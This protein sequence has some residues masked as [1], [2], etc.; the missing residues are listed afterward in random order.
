MSDGWIPIPGSEN[1][2]ADDK[3]EVLYE[4]R[5]PHCRRI[6]HWGEDDMIFN[7]PKCGA[8]LYD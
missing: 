3:L 7:C 4:G 8:I 1:I 6:I 5:C 2:P